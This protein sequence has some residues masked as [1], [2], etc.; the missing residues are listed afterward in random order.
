MNKINAEYGFSQLNHAGEHLCGDHVDVI[1]QEDNSKIIVIADGLGSGVKASILSTLTAKLIST[2]I[3]AG[4][5]LEECVKTVVA[6]LPIN[7][8]HGVAYCTF[9]I[10]HIKENHFVEI[11]QY[12]NPDVIFLRN[13]KTFDYPVLEVKVEDKILKVTEVELEPGD[14]LVGMSDGVPYANAEEA[15]NYDWT[16]KNIAE[17]VLTMNEGGYTAKN[18]AALLVD[19]CNKLYGEKPRDDVTACIIKARPYTEL[20]V[21]FGPPKNLDDGPFMMELFFNQSGKHAI[22]GGTTARIAG[23]YL[24]KSVLRG[25]NFVETDLPPMSNIEG[26][27]LVTE[28]VLT[29]SRVSEY[30][31]DYLGENK[32]FWERNSKKDGAGYL[33]RLMVEEATK[34]N[35]FVGTAA[36]P[37]HHN[38]MLELGL[39]Y[40][41]K[42][43]KDITNGLKTLGKSVTVEYF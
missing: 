6:T 19:E 32:L 23:C 31:E 37:A 12:E 26:V 33:Y 38:D 16:P 1:T 34:I 24:K 21:L 11:V 35:F 10:F 36:N 17:F 3:D 22:C 9:T 7:K 20:N 27:D 28:G 43:V 39:N 13:G 40:K 42:L 29:M 25:K 14:I 4:I 8:D 30:L 41:M 15:Y 2:M 18:I 5:G